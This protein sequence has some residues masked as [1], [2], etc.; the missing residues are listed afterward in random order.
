MGTVENMPMAVI[1]EQNTTTQPQ[2]SAQTARKYSLWH[3][4]RTVLCQQLQA[5][6]VCKL[7]DMLLVFI[8]I[9]K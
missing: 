1:P 9:H 4:V 2:Q 3:D 7:L 5:T 8:C 6:L